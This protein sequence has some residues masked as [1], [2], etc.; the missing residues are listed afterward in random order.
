MTYQV[1][2]DAV[3]AT[4]PANVRLAHDGLRVEW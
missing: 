4:L 3:T 2:Y 1:D